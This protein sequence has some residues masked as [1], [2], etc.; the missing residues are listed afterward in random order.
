MV[1][2]KRKVKIKAYTDSYSE[3][4][5]IMLAKFF[6]RKLYVKDSYVETTKNSLDLSIYFGFNLDIELDRDRKSVIS[7]N[8]RHQ[9]IKERIA[10]ILN[11][12][13]KIR[14]SLS[15]T[16]QVLLDKFPEIVY[17]CLEKNYQILDCINFNIQQKGA[18]LIWNHMIKLD[19]SLIEKYPS[20]NCHK[21]NS[22][23]KKNSYL[24]FLSILSS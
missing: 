19:E 14:S 21:I 11:D 13:E 24:R 9:K 16:E 15:N 5:E 1:K 12:F 7:N 23:I 6:E 18:N 4:G 17:K 2:S 8:E 3:I 22:F 10:Y 20:S